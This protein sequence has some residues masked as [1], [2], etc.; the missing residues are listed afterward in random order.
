MCVC[1]CV[2]PERGE[3]LV[4]SV[5]LRFLSVLSSVYGCACVCACV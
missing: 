3:A 5:F 4:S 2:A 1:V